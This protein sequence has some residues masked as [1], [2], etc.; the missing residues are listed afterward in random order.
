M[1]TCGRTNRHAV[2]LR[3]VFAFSILATSP[4]LFSDTTVS[5]TGSITAVSLIGAVTP[6]EIS[7]VG[8]TSFTLGMPTGTH[9]VYGLWSMERDGKPCYVATMTEDVNKYEEDS[10]AIKD[11]C[12]AKATSSEMKLE[13]GDV[14]FEQRTFVRAL[15]A[16]MDQDN[17]HVKGLQIRGSAIDGNGNVAELPAKY[18]ET[19]T[20][21]DSSVLS[22]KS[23]LSD[24]NAPI[25]LR[26]N[27]DNWKNWVECPEGRIAT[28]ITVHFGPESDPGSLTGIA[29]QCRAVSKAGKIEKL[30]E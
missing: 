2:A 12:G 14:E 28:A 7:G 24:L 4:I 18:A 9:G 20:S 22:G 26:R 1:H 21:P 29:L 10:G 11:L 13:F 8:G 25:A 15:R 30:A 19:S 5:K 27:C 3:A 23:M 16:C 17:S 6:T